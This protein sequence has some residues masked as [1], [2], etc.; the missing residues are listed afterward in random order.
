M[1][2]KICL[3]ALAAILAAPALAQS[4]YFDFGDTTQQTA[5][6]YNN[7]VTT[8][9][10]SYPN[11]IDDSGAVTGISATVND[12]F[13]PGSNTSG[14]T[15]PFGDASIFDAQATRDNV[16]GHV[17]AWAGFDANPTGGFILSGLSTD[18]S[19][20]YVFTFFGSRMG[21]ADN[22]ETYYSATGLN[23]DTVYLNTSNNESEV[24]ITTAIS[25]DAS[26]EIAIEVG[27]GPNN[28]NGSG[29]YYIGSMKIDVVPEPTSVMLLGLG[30]LCLLA[31]RR[32]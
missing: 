5:G 31:R 16:F 15:A 30:G 18:P 17:A 14:S 20:T 29:F 23:S 8:F 10:G 25:A 7:F 21:V 1:S 28:N 6:N 4:L 2:R 22:R 13:Y 24:A 11:L 32:A 9:E 3:V 12:I 26:G 19:V 27:A